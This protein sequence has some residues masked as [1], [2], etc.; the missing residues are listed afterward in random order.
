MN[1]KAR[2]SKTLRCVMW[3]LLFQ[4]WFLL[5]IEANIFEYIK[6]TLNAHKMTVSALPLMSMHCSSISFRQFSVD[7]QIFLV[8][9]NKI[10]VIFKLIIYEILD[11]LFSLICQEVFIVSF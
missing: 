9:L 6:R 2:F 1:H 4:T 5:T 3:Y 8:L 11:I 10:L 7:K